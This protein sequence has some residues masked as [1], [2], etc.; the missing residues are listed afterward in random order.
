MR[1]NY[2][3]ETI[4]VAKINEHLESFQYISVTFTDLFGLGH[5]YFKEPLK[6]DVYLGDNPK[7]NVLAEFDFGMDM[8]ISTKD[9]YNLYLNAYPNDEEGVMKRVIAT[10]KYELMH[11]FFHFSGDPNYGHLNWALYG[12]LKDRVTADDEYYYDD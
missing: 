1:D 6:V 3:I 2:T 12:N 8:E 11:S 10:L 4:E 9:E 7:E 5:L